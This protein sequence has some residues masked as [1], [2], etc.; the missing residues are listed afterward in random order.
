MVNWKYDVFLWVIGIV[1]DLFFREV[2]PRGSWKVPREGPVLFVAAPHANQV[3]DVP[4]CDVKKIAACVLAPLGTL[5]LVFPAW[6]SS[7][8]LTALFFL[9]LPL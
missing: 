1:I 2:V 7:L 4:S 8:V 6:P 3:S 9:V 5:A